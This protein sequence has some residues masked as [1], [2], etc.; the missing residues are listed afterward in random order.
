MDWKGI[1]CLP[2]LFLFLLVVVFLLSCYVSMLYADSAFACTHCSSSPF[3]FL[4]FSS[5]FS[6]IGCTHDWAFFFGFFVTVDWFNHYIYYELFATT[7]FCI[8]HTFTYAHSVGDNISPLAVPLPQMCGTYNWT[9]YFCIFVI[10]DG[11]TW[12]LYGVC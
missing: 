10:P 1:A 9:F 7:P 4:P 8:H 6:A 5:P 11:T 3:W 2:V 12:Y